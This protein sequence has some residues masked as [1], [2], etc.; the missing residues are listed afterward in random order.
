MGGR[1]RGTMFDNNLFYGTTAAVLNALSGSYIKPIADVWRTNANNST[2]TTPS[3]HPTIVA[4]P[5]AG[6]T[7][8]DESNIREA[9]GHNYSVFQGSTAGTTGA[10]A[11]THTDGSTVSDG[12]VEWTDIGT[13]VESYGTWTTI[14]SADFNDFANFDFRPATVSDLKLNG[15]DI[16]YGTTIGPFNVSP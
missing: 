16:G 15:T 2:V 13:V 9:N 14:D 5:G 11:P 8:T 10:T 6:A 1:A 3:S 4:H 12:T 7:M